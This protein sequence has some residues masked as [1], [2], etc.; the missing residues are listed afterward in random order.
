MSTFQG[1]W[2]PGLQLPQSPGQARASIA[3]CLHITCHILWMV[4]MVLQDSV[5]GL[6]PPCYFWSSLLEYDVFPE[7]T[8][9][10]SVAMSF[11]LHLSVDGTFR[12]SWHC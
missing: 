4:D 10:N 9:W 7:P 1:G 11:S 5:A 8:C 6:G 3:H 2:P 12:Q